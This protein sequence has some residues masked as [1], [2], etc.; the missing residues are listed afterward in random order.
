M[1]F[2]VVSLL[3]AASLQDWRYLAARDDGDDEY[4]EGDILRATG[5]LAGKSAGLLFKTVG[6]GVG[7]GLIRAT[8]Y[9]GEGIENGTSKIGARR[10]GTGVS[11]VVTGMG[12][13]VGDTVSGGK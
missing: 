3:S 4:V 1:K 12:H 10:F 2:K 9:M 8:S 5:N 11:S 6:R 13:G 7:G